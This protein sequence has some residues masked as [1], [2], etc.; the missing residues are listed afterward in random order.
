MRKI[1]KLQSCGRVGRI[2]F[3]KQKNYSVSIIMEVFI[4]KNSLTTKT[5]D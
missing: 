3:K 5:L 2:S 1:L 4:F